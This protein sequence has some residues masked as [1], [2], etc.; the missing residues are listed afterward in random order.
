MPRHW[1]LQDTNQR[2]C[3]RFA[4]VKG[5]R[6]AASQS[7][8]ASGRG[9][10]IETRHSVAGRQEGGESE[11]TDRV[12]PAN[13]SMNHIVALLATVTDCGMKLASAVICKL[14]NKGGLDS[15][16]TQCLSILL[17]ETTTES[18]KIVGTLVTVMAM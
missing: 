9:D 2:K 12:G 10:S 8:E 17:D 4:S 5:F 18:T 15:M 3:I 7:I 1:H 11:P 6:G 13:R 14:L 16:R